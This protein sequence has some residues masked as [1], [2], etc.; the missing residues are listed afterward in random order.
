MPLFFLYGRFSFFVENQRVFFFSTSIKRFQFASFFCLGFLR[1]FGFKLEEITFS[2][3]NRDKFVRGESYC[4]SNT[5][6]LG[7]IMTS[8]FSLSELVSLWNL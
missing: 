5:M 8:Y 4:A 6:N 7:N 3:M 2:I 1:F